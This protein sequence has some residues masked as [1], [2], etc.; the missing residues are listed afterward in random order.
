MVAGTRRGRYD[1]REQIGEGGMGVVYLARDSQ[2]HRDVAIK[3]LRPEVAGDAERVMRFKA[4]ARA[5]SALNHPNII[6]IYEIL[7]EDDQ[8]LIAYEY[9][10]GTTLREK[11]SRNQLSYAD[12]IKIF[13]Q[14]A[15]AI[16]AAHELG[17][18]H[19]DIKPENIMIRHDGYVK[20]LDFGLAKQSIFVSG[21]DTQTLQQVQTQKGQ[22]LGSI[23]YMSPEQVRDDGFDARTDIWSL[24][25]VLYE[26]L[27]GV[28]P[29]RR[30]TAAE[31][32]GAILYVEPEPVE[33]YI[34]GV[35]PGVVNT[36]E[37]ALKKNVADRCPDVR[38]LIS[39]LG[40]E[41]VSGSNYVSVGNIGRSQQEETVKIET[42]RTDEN[43]TLILDSGSHGDARVPDDR[44]VQPGFRKKLWGLRRWL[45]IPA[46]ALAA[47]ILFALYNTFHSTLFP[48][49]YNRFANQQV[50]Q[51]TNDGRSHSVAISPDGKF[52][53][54]VRDVDERQSLILKEIETGS[55]KEL[56][57]PARA[58][59]IRPTFSA[60]GEEIYYVKRE[61]DVGTLYRVFLKRTEY[62]YHV[63]KL[64][65][66]V[67]SRVT[68][69]PDGNSYA[70]IRHD[71]AANS[72]VIFIAERHFS[73]EA[74]L[75]RR[76]GTADTQ[77]KRFNEVS[78]QNTKDQFTVAGVM[79]DDLGQ[80]LQRTNARTYGELGFWE[81]GVSFYSIGSYELKN[82]VWLND[83]SHFYI[84]KRWVGD[85]AQIRY[86]VPG[87]YEGAKVI[88]NDMTN[89]SSF[90]VN[91]DGSKMAAAKEIPLSSVSFYLLSDKGSEPIITDDRNLSVVGGITQAPDGRLLYTKSID[92]PVF[93]SHWKN[94][95]EEKVRVAD[96][97]QIFSVDADGSNERQLTFDED[98]NRYPTPT[99]EGRY[100]LFVTNGTDISRMDADGGVVAKVVKNANPV[101][102]LQVTPYGRTV[103]Y[104]TSGEK[105]ALMKVPVDGGEPRMLIPDSDSSDFNPRISPDGKYLAYISAYYDKADSTYK[106][107]VKVRSFEKDGRLGETV[108]EETFDLASTMQ[109]SL[110]SSSLCFIERKGAENVWC[111]SIHDKN[112]SALTEFDSGKIS[113]FSWSG[114]ANKLLIVRTNFRNDIF[115]IRDPDRAAN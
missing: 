109:W 110:D 14:M 105:M 104:A 92:R 106:E 56:A 27:T 69:L 48:N 6:T 12:S 21:P 67:D 84:G 103:V 100:I 23:S 83:G 18:I 45:L 9:V 115:L 73:T 24:G 66:D 2:L 26:M 79:K 49:Y 53:S 54:F 57:A 64:I 17:I 74:T 51:L 33:E 95:I 112:E 16:A 58:S 46:G 91:S 114:D 41:A 4:E 55:E 1:I 65:V 87:L 108:V 38:Q 50:T 60:D 80:G 86:E 68:F 13:R 102:G 96:S 8:V 90:D 34:P 11:I 44:G 88:S 99:Q 52:V 10:K 75:A 28:N 59:F 40:D 62:P 98:Y 85:P 61:N 25:V 15:D 37:A 93:V 7:E 89:Y 72:D 29:F 94:R 47:L 19:R 113:S 36:I 78:W 77:F 42:Q 31:S 82:Y 30:G 5:A 3:I 111:W 76:L 101:E 63:Q 35:S 32:I 22:L 81:R 71:T 97:V 43:P 39:G 70:F 107:L 20:I